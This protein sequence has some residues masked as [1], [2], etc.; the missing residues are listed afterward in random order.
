VSLLNSLRAPIR[1]TIALFSVRPAPKKARTIVVNNITNIVQSRKYSEMKVND[2]RR[3]LLDLE[4]EIER[5][6]EE[7]RRDPEEKPNESRWR[8]YWRRVRRFARAHDHQLTHLLLACVILGLALRLS[9]V[10]TRHDEEV[11]TLRALLV[12]LL[13][14]VEDLHVQQ[15]LRDCAE[16]QAQLTA[17]TARVTQL[18]ALNKQQL[19]QLSRDLVLLIA[20]LQTQLN[21]SAHHA[22]HTLQTT[23]HVTAQFN[24]VLTARNKRRNNTANN[25]APVETSG[26]LPPPSELG[27]TKDSAPNSVK[28]EEGRVF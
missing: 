1:N 10:E 21:T 16:L 5:E 17:V 12:T 24:H 9:S 11:E 8:K 22:Q 13:T 23:S 18:S 19:T 26:T 7:W 6:R 27:D 2:P 3:I 14:L 4:A 25:S 20:Q 15:Q 28:S